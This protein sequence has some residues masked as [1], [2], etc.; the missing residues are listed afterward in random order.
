M[1]LI[2]NLVLFKHKTV[3]PIDQFGD[4]IHFARALKGI[5]TSRNDEDS[6]C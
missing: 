3:S 4:D 2:G 1:F 6:Y 5:L